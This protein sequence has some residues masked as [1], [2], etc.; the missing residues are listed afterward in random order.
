M[1]KAVRSLETSFTSVIGLPEPT[2]L[3]LPATPSVSPENYHA[4]QQTEKD[5]MTF[6]YNVKERVQQ[7]QDSLMQCFFWKKCS[8]LVLVCQ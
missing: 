2:H 5:Y 6:L 1:T 3:Q 8:V 4:L 7:G